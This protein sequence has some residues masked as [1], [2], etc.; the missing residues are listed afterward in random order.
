MPVVLTVAGGVALILFGVGYLRKGLDR[1]FGEKLGPWM[2]RLAGDRWRAFLGGVGISILTPSS[3]TI[4]VLAVQTVQA[5]QM[6]ARQ[7]LAVI[8]GADLGLTVMVLL[9]ALRAEQFAPVLI[10]LGVLVY[11]ISRSA[12]RRGLGQVLLALGLI[13]IAIGIIKSAAL[14]AGSNGDFIEMVRILDAIRR[15][16]RRRR[17]CWRLRCNRARRRSAWW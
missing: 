3:T 10:L 15:G 11:Q 14:T 4:S 17:W 5:G 2:Q 7:M 9:I 1:L 8:F 12:S 6:T 16:W 13:F